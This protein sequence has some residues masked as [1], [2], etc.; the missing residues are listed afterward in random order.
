MTSIPVR[1]RTRAWFASRGRAEGALIATAVLS[2][3]L[4]GI[5][6]A[7]E[8]TLAAWLLNVSWTTAAL[9]AVVSLTRG[10]RATRD[11]ERRRP[12]A[13]LALATGCWLAGQLVWDVYF[14]LHGTPGSPSFA[15]AFWLAFALIAVLGLSWFS[16]PGTATG[17]RRYAALDIGALDALVAVAVVI[18]YHD[19]FKESALPLFGRL[20][21]M[22]YAVL[23]VAVVVSVSHALFRRLSVRRH[24]ELIAV[25][26][27]ALLEAV[28]FVLWTPRLLAADY[29]IGAGAIDLLWTLDEAPALVGD[30]EHVGRQLEEAVEVRLRDG[31]S[32]RTGGSSTAPRYARGS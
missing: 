14:L 16:A 26:I 1:Q 30:A 5:A 11:R 29:V 15:D 6:Y 3:C 23:Y 22:A 27:G 8:G 31:R 19:A 21:S 4:A 20:T 10:A 12:W 24:P 28:A 17:A 25:A 18:F 9:F 2:V 7:F 13:A 32:R